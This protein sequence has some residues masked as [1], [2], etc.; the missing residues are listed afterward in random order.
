METYRPGTPA[1]VTAQYLIATNDTH[2]FLRLK[3]SAE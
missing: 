1:A 2:H 3:V